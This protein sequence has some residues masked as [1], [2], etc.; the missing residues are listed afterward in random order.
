MLHLWRKSIIP[1]HLVAMETSIWHTISASPFLL[2]HQSQKWGRQ[3]REKGKAT[4][5]SQL[6]QHKAFFTPFLIICGP[7]INNHLAPATHLLGSH[8]GRD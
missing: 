4:S 7:E 5:H 6:P 1:L 8:L 2:W 3:A